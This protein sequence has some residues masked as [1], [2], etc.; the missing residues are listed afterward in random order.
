MIFVKECARKLGITGLVPLTQDDFFQIC[1]KHEIEVIFHNFS[2]CFYLEEPK[3]SL[4]AIFLSN[5]LP[6]RRLLEVSF[7]ELG[8]YC[9]HGGMNINQS[10]LIMCSDDPFSN[11]SKQEKEADQFMKFALRYRS[12]PQYRS[13]RLALV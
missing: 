3:T 6:K 8:H 9:L 10:P 1:E 7:H 11:Y 4:K 2:S 12:A 13:K 5:L